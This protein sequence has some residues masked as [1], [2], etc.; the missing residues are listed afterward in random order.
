MITQTQYIDHLHKIKQI[1]HTRGTI[2]NISRLGG[3][4]K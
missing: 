2:K 4:H 3:L 1:K